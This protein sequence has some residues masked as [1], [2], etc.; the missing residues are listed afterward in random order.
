MLF[1]SGSKVV[2]IA[3]ATFFSVWLNSLEGMR[4]VDEK[5]KEVAVILEKNTFE[6]M[7]KVVLPAATPG[8]L[9]GLRMGI[10]NAWKAVVTAEMLAASKGLGYMITYAREMV[11][12]ATVFIGVIIIGIVGWILDSLLLKLQN[13]LLGWNT[14]ER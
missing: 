10:S 5:F 3:L 9:T 13:R 2:V 7:T 4:A 6:T 1:R 11:Q 14:S 8:I 12:T